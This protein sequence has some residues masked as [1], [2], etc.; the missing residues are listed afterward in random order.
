MY[1]MSIFGRCLGAAGVQGHYGEGHWHYKIPGRNPNFK[2]SAFVGKTET[3]LKRSGNVKSCW[4]FWEYIFPSWAR[5]N[6]FSGHTLNAMGLPG[7]GIRGVLETGKLQKRTEPFGISIMAV[8]ATLQK[9]LDELRWI[10]DAIVE[11]VARTGFA[12]PAIFIQVNRSC[13][14]TGHN[15]NIGEIVEESQKG[16]EV[17]SVLGWLLQEKFAIDT[18]PPEAV[19]EL[20]YNPYCDGICIGNTVKFSFR[21]LGKK[22]FGKDVSPLAHLGGGGISGPELLPLHCDYIKKLRDLG[23]EKN[24]NGGGGIFCPEDVNKYRDAAADSVFVGTVA[25]HHPR[26]VAPIIQRANTLN[27]R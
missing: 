14:N 5:I 6:L 12:A 11:S 4:H 19:K 17:L 9:R 15:I 21:G 20:Q 16:L 3:W 1:D 27:W 18:A 13:P 7:H 10:T 25:T 22:I 24:I 8:E 23:F 26:R 2:G